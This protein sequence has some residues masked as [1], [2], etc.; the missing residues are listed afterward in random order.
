MPTNPL[1]A[2]EAEQ[3]V[4]RVWPD[5]NCHLW[6]RT[7]RGETWYIAERSVFFRVGEGDSPDAAWIDAA[8]RLPAEER[9]E[10]EPTQYDS[11]KRCP[12]EE[13][14]LSKAG[15]DCSRYSAA[16][17][18]DYR[19]LYEQ[20]RA[21]ADELARTAREMYLYVRYSGVSVRAS[22]DAALA[23]YQSARNPKEPK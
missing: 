5:A 1:S 7:H 21:L 15:C 20:E 6:N 9:G 4:K 11:T 18:P 19:T 14:G 2:H 3:R 23:A 8:S 12:C 13:R 16:L 22:W 10:S 17:V